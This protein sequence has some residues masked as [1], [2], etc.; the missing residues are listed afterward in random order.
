MKPFPIP[1]VEFLQPGAH[2]EDEALNYLSMPS[3]MSTYQAPAQLHPGSL[4]DKP[5]AL[6]VFNEVVQVLEAGIV[7]AASVRVPLQG[8]QPDELAIV[9]QVLGEGEV[10]ALADGAGAGRQVRAQESVFAGVW[11]VITL[12][13]EQVV[14][15]WIEVGPVPLHFYELSTQDARL[16]RPGW[17]GALPAGVHSAP[18][19]IDEIED[20]SRLWRVG[21]PPQV[22]NLTLLPVSPEDIAFLDHCLG[23]GQLLVLSRGY[24]N[25]R[26]TNT[27][28]SHCWRVVYYNSSDA[29]ILNTVEV[30]DMP[31]VTKAA[32]E[33]LQDSCARLRDIVGYLQEAHA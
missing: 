23:T 27:R 21:Q 32:P 15:D 30:V 18:L 25:C 8:L 7:A 4:A 16:P 29:V 19:L 1:V 33:D 13:G 2:A 3:D 17:K 20:H 14:D 22:V 6:R 26:I 24:G 11:R 9:N 10:S 12:E 31:E 28:L 5:G